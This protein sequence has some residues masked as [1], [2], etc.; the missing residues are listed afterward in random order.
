MKRIVAVILIILLV[1]PPASADQE[2]GKRLNWEQATRQKAGTEIM[3]TVADSPPAKV[4]LLFADDSILVT[5]KPDAPKL[6]G[7]L[8]GAL[9]KVG[10]DWPVILNGAGNFVRGHVRVSPE[11]IFDGDQKVAELAAVI[12]QTPHGDVRGIWE[13]PSSHPHRT[14]N[15]VIFAAVVAGA[16]FLVSAIAVLTGEND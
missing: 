15:I 12:Q 6:P 9:L 11:G 4:K 3:L 2:V 16:L 8:Q 5:L 10:P 13:P 7:K 14:R 1:A